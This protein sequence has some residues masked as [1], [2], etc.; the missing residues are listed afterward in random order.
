MTTSNIASDL[1]GLAVPVGNLKPLPDNPRKGDV[2][3]VA[4]SYKQFG[5]LKPIVVR[6]SKQTK[7]GFPTG[8]VLAGNHQ[9]LAAIQL[10]WST[11]AVVWTDTDAKT[12]K[13]FA[14]ADNRTHDLGTYNKGLLVDLL[15]ELEGDKALFEATGYL[16]ERPQTTHSPNRRKR[17]HRRTHR[18]RRSTR[19][20]HQSVR[21]GFCVG[22]RRPPPRLW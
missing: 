21:V 5:Q 22:S 19:G 17:P 12:A 18:P 8:T 2:D 11:I 6:K 9:L 20:C 4:A 15:K 13:A 3:A 14:L 1:L 10:G 7:D 16:R